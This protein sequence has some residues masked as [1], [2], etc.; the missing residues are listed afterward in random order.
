MKCSISSTLLT[1]SMAL[2]ACSAAASEP[3]SLQA[4]LEA[5]T[6]GQSVDRRAAIESQ[7]IDAFSAWHAGMIKTP[8]G[9]IPVEE[10][11]FAGRN[12]EYE[13]KRA[14]MEKHPAMH[15][16]LA[17]WCSRHELPDQ[18]RAHYF[19]ALM[20]APNNIEAR[21]YLGHVR[22]GD[23]WI[24]QTKLAAAQQGFRS[25]LQKLEET[26]P[27]VRAIVEDI[28]SGVPLRI[29]E[30]LDQL[31]RLDSAKAL[32]AL[33]FFAG[34]IDD[35]LAKPLIRKIA[36]V[37]SPKACLA[38]VRVAL[39][40]P[41]PAIRTLTAETIRTYPQHY[42]VP[43][44][45]GMLTT[46]AKVANNI[47]MHPNG[48]IGLDT[49]V[50][51]ELQNRKQAKRAQKLV[52]VVARFSSSRFAKVN[53]DTTGDISYWSEY[54]NV[55]TSDPVRF[56]KVS[57]SNLLYTASA[58]KKLTYVP[59]DV[60]ATAAQNMFEMAKQQERAVAQQ[61]RATNERVNNVCSL[62]RATT[63]EELEDKAETWW[64]WWNDHNERYQNEKPTEYAYHQQRERI[65]INSRSYGNTTESKKYDFGEMLI[66]YSCLVPGTL[67]QTSAGLRPIE[68]IKIGD[69]VLSQDVET[70]ELTLK[71]VILTTVR[72]PKSTIKIRTRSGT[73]E[74]TGGHLWWVSGKG[75]MKTRDLKP[76]MF[77]HSATGTT[78]ITELAENPVLQP[79]YNLVVDGFNTYFVG[80]ERV[81][82]YDNTVLKPT[83][84]QLPGF[85]V[86]ESVAD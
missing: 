41:S 65:G 12:E 71:P 15:L 63:G 52:N 77:L 69:L 17:R 47:V 62:L 23:H 33:E 5:E 81:L 28:H 60:A 54:W 9:W 55:P 64:T 79:T 25:S 18:A 32:C 19:G 74:A 39:L 82:S 73:I 7:P 24:E 1:T 50:T 36:S 61:N 78:R 37:R 20:T 40:H 48:N 31:E 27:T 3:D 13:A 4:L 59:R 16:S 46:Q 86:L 22:I 68:Q 34:H 30:G 8:D 67:V 29:A 2:A 56:G 35:D 75:W 45:L 58:M 21:K 83:L 57:Q 26:A 38:L 43:T 14:S 70:A 84:R 6:L 53:A 10:L 66:Q 11:S 42:F 80:S 72:P 51:H 49:I 76:N 85:G 44:L